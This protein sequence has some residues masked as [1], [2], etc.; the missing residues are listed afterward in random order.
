MNM[1]DEI[2]YRVALAQGFL[3]EA[4]QDASLQRWRSCVSNAQLVVE[5]V[6]KAILEHFG[7]VAKTHEPAREIAAIVRNNAEDV[8]VLETLKDILPDLLSIGL[9]EHILTDYGDETSRTLPWDLFDEQKAKVALD[10]AR[11][12]LHQRDVFRAHVELQ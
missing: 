11:R 12:C 6:G 1:R 5:N 9:R 8:E 3:K 7:V 2:N 10:S 4:E